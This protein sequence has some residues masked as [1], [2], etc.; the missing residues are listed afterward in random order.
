MKFL[1]TLAGFR[2]CDLIYK[3]EGKRNMRKRR[4]TR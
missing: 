4:M 1:R 2:L 3:E